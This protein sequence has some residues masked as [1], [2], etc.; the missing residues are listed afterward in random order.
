MSE[1]TT[2]PTPQPR[3]S[4]INQEAVNSMF[5]QSLPI[6]YLAALILFVSLF[7]TS[8]F[9]MVDLVGFV[10]SNLLSGG[11]SASLASLFKGLV[12]NSAALS[13]IALLIV[14]FPAALFAM[15]LVRHMEATEPWR[16]TQRARRGVYLVAITLL[17]FV[18]ISSV[19]TFIHGLLAAGAGSDAGIAILR[20]LL[21]GI[22]AIAAAVAGLF[23]M[24]NM[25][26]QRNQAS[27]RTT[28]LILGVAAVV[29]VSFGLYQSY[30]GSSSTSSSKPARSSS[31]TTDDLFKSSKPS[32]NSS[33]SFDFDS[34]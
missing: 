14:S 30:T 6:P 2:A 26:A 21:Q 19:V 34:F 17:L 27:I 3:A 25:Y 23:V 28:L 11:G 24:T 1:Q 18:L 20:T 7:I 10:M 16:H 29:L 31:T 12:G 22:V 13:K 8:V 4:I 9:T 5:S 33:R 15:K 32:S